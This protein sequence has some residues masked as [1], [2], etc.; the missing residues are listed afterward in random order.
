MNASEK[1]RPQRPYPFTVDQ[2]TGKTP[3]PLLTMEEDL[4]RWAEL[5]ALEEVNPLQ[6]DGRGYGDVF[7]ELY[8]GGNM[9]DSH[10]DRALYLHAHGVNPQSLFE[11]CMYPK[12]IKL[13]GPGSEADAEDAQFSAAMLHEASVYFAFW[14][15]TIMTKRNEYIHRLRDLGW[16]QPEIASLLGVSKQRVHS[17]LNS[18][19]APSLDEGYERREL[20]NPEVPDS[21]SE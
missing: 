5:D 9:D 15:R 17:I 7:N 21:P 18:P 13:Y 4:K 11:V 8:D 1:S 10:A 19:T 2:V 3:I 12:E 20:Y 14:A 6:D 16:T